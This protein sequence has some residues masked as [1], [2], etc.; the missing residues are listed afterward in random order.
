MSKPTNILT[1]TTTQ[2]EGREVILKRIVVNKDVLS[3]VITIYDNT[4][5][6]VLAADPDGISTSQT[7]A[8][9]GAQNLTITGA[10][11]SGGVATL[12]YRR[13]VT[14]T[15]AADD[16]GRTFTV[17][18]TDANGVALTEDITGPNATL[19]TGAKEFLTVTQIS[20]DANTA[21]AV[22]AGAAIQVGTI[23]GKITAPSTLLQ[24]NYTLEYGVACRFGLTLVTSA[25]TDITVVSE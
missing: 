13:K 21:G 14:I 2:V 23:I 7:P 4:S 9:G 5:A 6:G 8:A 22:T 12:G 1:A 24:T 19:V 17:T 25:A 3:S 18:G 20:V 10:L 11:A 15:A 16:S